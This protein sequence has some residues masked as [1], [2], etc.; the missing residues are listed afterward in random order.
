MRVFLLGVS[1]SPLYPRAFKAVIQVHA[2]A[3][4]PIEA[5]ASWTIALSRSQT[6]CRTVDVTFPHGCRRAL[7]A[8]Q[9]ND[10]GWSARMKLS[11]VESRGFATAKGFGCRRLV[12]AQPITSPV[13]SLKARGESTR[14]GCEP[15]ISRPACGE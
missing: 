9:S 5:Y 10:F 3:L 7:R 12:I 11:R 13:L 8:R 14:N 2:D 6:S 15:A 4:I 1:A